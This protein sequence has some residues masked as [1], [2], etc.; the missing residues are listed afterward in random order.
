MNTTSIALVE[1]LDGVGGEHHGR[2]AVGEVAETRDDLGARDRVEPG[3]RLVEEE[4]VRVREQ[5]D[6]DAGALA[7]PAAE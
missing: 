3:R 6:G 7:L 2:R 1:V 5:L 4:D